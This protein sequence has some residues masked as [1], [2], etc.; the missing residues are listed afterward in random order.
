MWNN[1]ISRSQLL[2]KYRD[3][4]DQ[5]IWVENGFMLRRW[6]I[7][8]ICRACN[9]Q[10]DNQ[11]EKLYSIWNVMQRK[12]FKSIFHF[13]LLVFINYFQLRSQISLLVL[14][15]NILV[16]NIWDERENTHITLKPQVIYNSHILSRVWQVF[17]IR[18]KTQDQTCFHKIGWN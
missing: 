8:S 10:L 14:L 13:I 1:P 18:F 6:T 3:Y 15:I 4:I 11:F 16:Y 12:W 7:C 17:N 5:S 9:L 2:G